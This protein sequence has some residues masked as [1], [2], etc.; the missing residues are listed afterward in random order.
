MKC[1]SF[2][3][4]TLFCLLI[5]SCR[6]EKEV[7][8]VINRAECLIR[9][10]ALDSARVLLD[11]I[12]VLESLSEKSYARVALS[13]AR[14]CDQQ[15]EDM[16]FVVQME[17]AC[18]YY[19]DYGTLQ[20]QAESQLYVGR[21]YEE[22]LDFDKAMQHY[23]LAADIA[24]KTNDYKL[25][26]KIYLR[27]AELHDFEDRD[28]DTQRFCEMAADVFLK[29]NDSIAYAYALRDI[30]WVEIKRNE[31]SDALKYNMK[32]L[33]LAEEIGDS[34][35]LSSVTNRIGINYQRMDS[36]K[37]SEKY[38][39]QSIAYEEEGSAPTYLV[40]GNLH[41][42]QKKYKEALG[43]VQK[44]SGMETSNK[45][46]K[47]GVLFFYYLLNKETGGLDEAIDYYEQ[48]VAFKDSI[49]ELQENMNTIKVEK[50]YEQS[51]LLNNNYLL[52]NRYQKMIIISFVLLLLCLLLFLYYRHRVALKDK[53]ILEQQHAL[54]ANHVVLLEKELMLKGLEANIQQIRIN[55]LKKSGIWNVVLERSQNM[56]LAKKKPLSDKE[57]ILL[58]ETV[59]TAYISFYE[60]LQKKFQ[61]LTQDEIHFCTLLK[62][63]LSSQ[64]LS[65]LLNIQPASV[66]H[67]RYRIMKKGG[68]ENTNTTLEEFIREM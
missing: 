68:C 22:E 9:A 60:N 26:G 13:L 29:A 59:R 28:D 57:W 23:L 10:N 21:A 43:Y 27:A 30:A 53:S 64:Q 12:E 2:I 40:L 18:D 66:S 6:N 33:K 25:T 17:R 56:E 63:E 20:E 7:N 49:S 8:L 11:S 48:Y 19:S 61:S 47:G 45:M 55:I 3:Y 44:A 41:I 36:F 65:I 67:K 34:S 38:L 42:D 35:L 31:L 39:L 54:Q 50:R 51:L 4:V 62:L 15:Q 32:A 46:F 1:L 5:S 37:L 24:E 14:I 58:V 52:Q 16:P